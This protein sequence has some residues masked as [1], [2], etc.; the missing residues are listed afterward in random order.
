MQLQREGGISFGNTNV[1]R[2]V[3]NVT[4]IRKNIQNINNMAPAR[5]L[6]GSA[7]PNQLFAGRNIFGFPVNRAGINTGINSS[8]HDEDKRTGSPAN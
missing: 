3:K 4:T 1:G 2:A 8:E 5:P 6:A 7:G